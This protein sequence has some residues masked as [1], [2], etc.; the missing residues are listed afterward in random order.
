MPQ[1]IDVLLP[2]LGDDDDAVAK[3]IVSMWLAVVGQ[4]LLEGDDLLEITT[5]KAAFV[6]PSPHS[7]ALTAQCVA[8][9]D[10]IRVGQ[11]I[12]VLSVE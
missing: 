11:L 6:V 5:D 2:S 3:G 4:P 8:E 9:G 1:S 10:T 12:A 7:G